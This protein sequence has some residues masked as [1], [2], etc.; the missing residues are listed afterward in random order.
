VLNGAVYFSGECERCRAFCGSVCCRGYAFVSL[1]QEEAESGRYIH[2]EVQEGCDC[3]LCNRMREAGV[4]YALY[5]RADGACVYLD[6]TGK[7]GI[8][9]DRPQTCRNYSCRTVAF[10]VVP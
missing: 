4:R 5:K 10:R 9:D 1:T 7:C 2:K 8:Y 6:G 3:A